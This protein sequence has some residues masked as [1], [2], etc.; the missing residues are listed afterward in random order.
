[1]DFDT[2]GGDVFLFEFSRQ[3][4]LDKGGLSDASVADEDE[5]ELGDVIRWGSLR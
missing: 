1:V 2:K 5:L 3:V 4:T